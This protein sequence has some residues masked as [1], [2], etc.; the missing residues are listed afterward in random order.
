MRCTC[1]VKTVDELRARATFIDRYLLEGAR[2][3]TLTTKT[4][5]DLMLEREC[6]S[7]HLYGKG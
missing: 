7:S 5:R 6:V 2:D 1:E 4:A 3:G